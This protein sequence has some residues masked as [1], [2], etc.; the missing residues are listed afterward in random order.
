MVKGLMCYASDIARKGG[1]RSSKGISI[2]FVGND[3]VF[4]LQ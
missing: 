1:E 2:N 3:F 4:F